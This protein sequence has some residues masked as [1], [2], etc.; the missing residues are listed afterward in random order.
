MSNDGFRFPVDSNSQAGFGIVSSCCQ[1]SS[2]GCDDEIAAAVLLREGRMQQWDVVMC[3]VHY[4]A[5]SM[6]AVQQNSNLLVYNIQNMRG[7]R[8][9]FFAKDIEKLCSCWRCLLVVMMTVV[10]DIMSA[11]LV[12]INANMSK[13]PTLASSPAGRTV[14]MTTAAVKPG[15]CVSVCWR[16]IAVKLA[17]VSVDP[18]A[19]FFNK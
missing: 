9:K 1:P 14:T 18:L 19:K 8:K 5:L 13:S 17:H 11:T 10:N 16:L 15:T 7:I 12:S 3:V 2:S 4:I 6:L